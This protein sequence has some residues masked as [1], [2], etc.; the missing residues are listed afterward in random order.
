MLLNSSC[1]VQGAGCRVQDEAATRYQQFS[2]INNLFVYEDF[3]LNYRYLFLL[4]CIWTK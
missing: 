2:L 4:F 3:A 1:R